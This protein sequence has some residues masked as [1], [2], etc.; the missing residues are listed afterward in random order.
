MA[1]PALVEAD[2]EW[3]RSLRLVLNCRLRSSTHFSASRGCGFPPMPSNTQFVIDGI[4]MAVDD[5]PALASASW[6]ATVEHLRECCSRF[7]R[8]R[9]QLLGASHAGNATLKFG[10][11]RIQWATYAMV[12]DVYLAWCVLDG[13]AKDSA[14]PEIRR[15]AELEWPRLVAQH[16]TVLW[17]AYAPDTGT[18]KTPGTASELQNG[19][20]GVVR[21]IDGAVSQFRG[22]FLDLLRS[23]LLMRSFRADTLRRI[24]EHVRQALR[25][26]AVKFAECSS[27]LA[28]GLDSMA[29]AA[30]V[31]QLILRTRQAATAVPP[32]GIPVAVLAGGTSSGRPL[33]SSFRRGF[34]AGAA[35]KLLDV[36]VMQLSDSNRQPFACRQCGAPFKSS[37]ACSAHYRVHFFTRAQLGDTDQMVRLRPC[38]REAFL[39]HHVASGPPD[40]SFIA[41]VAPI[42]TAYRDEAV[43]A[44]RTASKATSTTTTTAPSAAGQPLPAASSS[45]SAAAAGLR[46][47]PRSGLWLVDDPSIPVTCVVCGQPIPSRLDTV[48][49]EWVLPD[50]RDAPGGAGG[51]CHAACGP[52]SAASV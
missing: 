11:E 51:V 45:S 47:R 39:A 16:M 6:Q 48:S 34:H 46:K 41:T 13:V 21:L 20:V 32:A 29:S 30:A 44:V 4:V 1:S 19:E 35:T 17:E 31:A 33:L 37:A 15:V 27:S 14:V 42:K 24:D 49:G 36:T 38:S 9:Q 8:L 25:V 23:W 50:A 18:S 2:H 40:G 12:Q 52:A 28:S 22:L 7:H 3:I 26:A 43:V 5:R 10:V